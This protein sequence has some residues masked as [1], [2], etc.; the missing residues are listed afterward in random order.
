MKRV[1]VCAALQRFSDS[2]V[3]CGARHFD[4]LMVSQVQ[5]L[6]GDW[7]EPEQGFI[8]NYGKFLTREMAYLVAKEAGQIV[9]R[10]GGDNETL[11]SE[12]LY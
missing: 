3:I 6:G 4:D 5:E 12:N 8:D 7:D 2:L 11:Y 10:V 1:I 9:R